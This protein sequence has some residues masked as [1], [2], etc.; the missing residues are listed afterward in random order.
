MSPAEAPCLW[1]LLSPHP[2]L[3]QFIYMQCGKQANPETGEVHEWLRGAGGWGVTANEYMVSFEAM[4][5]LEVDSS[6]GCTSC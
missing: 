4:K 3:R 2:K 5:I 6:A 1:Y